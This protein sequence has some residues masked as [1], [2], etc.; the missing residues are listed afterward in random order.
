MPDASTLRNLRT[1]ILCSAALVGLLA[2]GYYALRI[3]AA[4]MLVVAVGTVIALP[5]AAWIGGK[6][7][8]SSMAAITSVFGKECDP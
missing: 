1:F 6:A 7:W 2:L 5:L 4:P 3:A 8:A